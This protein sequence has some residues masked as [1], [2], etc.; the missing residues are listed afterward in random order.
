[1]H[2]RIRRGKHIS[3]RDHHYFL[4][5][6]Q[7][8]TALET[9]REMSTTLLQHLCPA[10]IHYPNEISSTTTIWQPRN[11]AAEQSSM[12]MVNV[13]A[14]RTISAQ[15]VVASTCYRGMHAYTFQANC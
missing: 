11:L 9:F 12:R 14:R 15:A 13:T 2:I 3:F 10:R 1:M 6:E 8:Y 7:E 5:E 4:S